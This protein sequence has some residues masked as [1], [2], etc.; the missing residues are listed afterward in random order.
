MPSPE[1]QPLSSIALIEV[2]LGPWPNW[3]EPWIESCRHNPTITW[4]MFCDRKPNY[5]DIPSNVQFIETTTAE[6][7]KRAERALGWETNIRKAYKMCDYRPVY[8]LMF[9]DHLKDTDYWGWS[10]N[11]LIWGNIRDWI[12]EERLAQY[13]ILTSTRCC[14]AG[15]FT[16]IQNTQSNNT[17][18]Q[19]IDDYPNLLKNFESSTNACETKLNLAVLPLE[20]SDTLRVWRR[21]IQATDL[22]SDKWDTWSREVDVKE[23]AQDIPYQWTSGP[24]RWEDGKIIHEATNTEWMFFHFM[25]WKPVWKRQHKTRLWRSYKH[26]FLL[27]EEGIKVVYDSK[28]MGGLNFLI[29]QCPFI[30]HRKIDHWIS[31]LRIVLGAW[32][33]KAL[34][35]G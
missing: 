31:S 2:W 4:L 22:H 10:D 35:K 24:C 30:I 28:V 8:G 3:F 25:H 11:D 18:Y 7:E 9:A 1:A 21:Q 19:H 20:A 27:Q 34:K 15:Q 6:I 17:L 13:D 23:P 26:T 16:I 29:T 12:T 14:I 5:A 33:N 32:K